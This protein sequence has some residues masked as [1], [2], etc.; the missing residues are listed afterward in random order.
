MSR[1]HMVYMGNNEALD[2][3]GSPCDRLPPVHRAGA[4]AGHRTARWPPY[5]KATDG[6]PYCLAA[7]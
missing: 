3:A 7:R 5:M 1:L 2:V 4:A 6:H